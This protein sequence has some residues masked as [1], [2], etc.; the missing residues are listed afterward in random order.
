MVSA[1]NE[2]GKEKE[3]GGKNRNPVDLE[4]VPSRAFRYGVCGV[5]KAPLEKGRE[6]SI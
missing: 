5:A 4:A 2:A 6:F 3:I 1:R